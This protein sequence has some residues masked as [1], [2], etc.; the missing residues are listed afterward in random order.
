VRAAARLAEKPVEWIR[1]KSIWDK[2]YWH[3][4][5]ARLGDS[6]KVPVELVVNGK[7]VARREIVADGRV[8]DLA[9]DYKPTRS[10]WIAVRTFPSSHTNPIFV[11]IDG[12]PIRASKRSAQWCLDAVDVCWKSKQGQIREEEK[13]AARAA[14]DRA[15]EVY[16]QIL[17][18]CDDAP[19][20]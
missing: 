15:E 19:D 9:F 18:E 13:P 14:Y 8:H 7:A 6:R 16:R 3:V 1:E 2:P 5:R 17:A 12:Q 4:E 20:S 11:E 10:C